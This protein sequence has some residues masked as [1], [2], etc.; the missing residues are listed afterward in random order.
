[1]PEEKGSKT[2]QEIRF[3]S[4][5][6]VEEVAALVCQFSYDVVAGTLTRLIADLAVPPEELNRLL[7]QMEKLEKEIQNG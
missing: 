2:Q 6:R 5:K 4:H 3:R 1:M 7:N